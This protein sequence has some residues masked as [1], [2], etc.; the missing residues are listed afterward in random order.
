M[1]CNELMELSE[2]RLPIKQ[3]FDFGIIS[4]EIRARKPDPIGFNLIVKQFNVKPEETIFIDDAAKNLTNA[5]EM[6]IKTIL[7]SDI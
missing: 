2:E 1:H 6:G 4:E 5:K 7:F 3:Y